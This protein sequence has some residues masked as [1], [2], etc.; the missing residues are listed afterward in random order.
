MNM[1]FAHN[2]VMNVKEKSDAGKR[3]EELTPRMSEKVR[4]QLFRDICGCSQATVSRWNTGTSPI[5]EKNAKSIAQYF[6]V[7]AGWVRFGDPYDKYIAND[8]CPFMK[9]I[10]S[11]YGALTNGDREDLAVLAE[12]K[13]ARNA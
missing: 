1:Q 7:N 13:A 6:K 10:R 4:V 8:D 11:K 3:L 2:Y 12:T 5:G 9:R